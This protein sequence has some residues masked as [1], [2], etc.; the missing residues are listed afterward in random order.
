MTSATPPF[1]PSAGS[2]AELG[3]QQWHAARLHDLRSP[4]GNLALVET[5]WLAPEAPAVS[6]EEALAGW[7][8]TVSVTRL[9]RANLETNEPEHGL[10]FWDSRSPAIMNFNTVSIF[11]YDPEWVVDAT[12]TPAASGRTVQFEHIR[13]NGGSRALAVPGDITFERDGTAYSLSAFDD[14]GV[15]LLVFG[16]ATN[17]AADDT[18]TYGAGRFLFVD[19]VLATGQ[20]AAPGPVRLDFNRAFVP[21]CG[22]SDQYNCPLPPVQ[23][24]FATAVTAGERTVLFTDGSHIS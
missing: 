10:R 14:A 9:T 2:T 18:G 19:R 7:P 5:R 16:D 13:D 22:F 17:G 3:R 15:L 6:D 23:N 1:S 8:T 20:F 4:Q 24:R 21:P 12:F 11:D